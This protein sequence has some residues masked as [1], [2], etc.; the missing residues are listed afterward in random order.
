M[1]FEQPDFLHTLLAGLMGGD[2]SGAYGDMPPAGSRLAEGQAPAQQPARASQQPAER[3]ILQEMADYLSPLLAGSMDQARESASSPFMMFQNRGWAS[4]H[5]RIAGAIEA[6]L[7]GAATTESGDT[8]GENISNVARSVLGGPQVRQDFRTKR[9][10]EP[11]QFA[12]PL[13]QLHQMQRQLE[14]SNI[15]NV[16]RLSR[17]NYYAALGAKAGQPGEPYGN[18][19]PSG[20][21]LWNMNQQTGV[22][23]PALDP[24]TGE[25]LDDPK[26]A[27][28]AALLGG[29]GSEDERAVAGEMVSEFMRGLGPEP[30]SPEWLSS[31]SQRTQ[32]RK[33][34]RGAT[35]AGAG[36]AARN[37]ANITAGTDTPD[38]QVRDIGRRRAKLERDI[39]RADADATLSYTNWLFRNR[40]VKVPEGKTKTDLYNEFVA[41]SQ[42]RV[43]ALEDE[44]L[45]LEEIKTGPVDLGA[46]PASAAPPQKRPGRAAPKTAADYLKKFQ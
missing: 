43:Q 19:I 35:L 36:A 4:R 17:A 18:P 32:S 11:M 31:F 30:G 10:L 37:Q 22:Y 20:G 39:K 34:T 29:R 16:E 7:L 25:Q 27:G 8:I 15:E 45:K 46:P 1:A 24:I 28:M 2:P 13:M 21:K 40:G 14:N 23:S 9:A 38:A 26:T 3:N 41:A 44:L 12:A 42:Q 6:G 33:L 5:P